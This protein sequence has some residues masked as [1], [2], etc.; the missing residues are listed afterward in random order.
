MTGELGLWQ[1]ASAGSAT[2]VAGSHKGVAFEVATGG[3]LPDCRKGWGRLP[4]VE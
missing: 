4:V 1:E 3:E 2:T